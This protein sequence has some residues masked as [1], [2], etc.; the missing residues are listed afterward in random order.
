MQYRHVKI[1]SIFPLSCNIQTLFYWERKGELY[2][3]YHIRLIS[4]YKN[5][6]RK[7]VTWFSSVIGQNASRQLATNSENLLASAQF[8]VALVTS[9]SQF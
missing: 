9:E 4:K 3:G 8:L 1:H 6:K 5:F 7:V 2:T